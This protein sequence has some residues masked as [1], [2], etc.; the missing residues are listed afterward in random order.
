MQDV[1]P[2][3]LF[4]IEKTFDGLLSTIVLFIEQDSFFNAPMN[5]DVI[6]QQIYQENFLNYKM[7]DG[8]SISDAIFT[9]GGNTFQNSDFHVM[10]YEKM[11]ETLVPDEEAPPE[12]SSMSYCRLKNYSGLGLPESAFELDLCLVLEGGTARFVTMEQYLQLWFILGQKTPCPTVNEQHFTEVFN[13][14]K[15]FHTSSPKNFQDMLG[16]LQFPFEYN[17][18]KSIAQNRRDFKDFFSYLTNIRCAVIEGSHWCEAA[19]QVLQGY[20][21]GDPIPLEYH[22]LNVPPSSTLF[23]HIT[24][25]VYSCNNVGQKLND[26]VFQH[27]KEKSKNVAQQKELIVT[28]S[29]HLFFR[30]VLEDLNNNV[31]LEEV[32]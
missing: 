28:E 18:H 11:T 17:K 16:A 6:F 14:F 4:K 10:F 7:N 8:L 1:S 24:T 12:I 5:L 3:E 20:K 27:L 19:C 9:E 15:N 31:E 2:E 22:E 32:I 26:T 13:L 21:L 29:W 30:K 25:H 23:K